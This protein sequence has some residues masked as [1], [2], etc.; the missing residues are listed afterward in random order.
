MSN[1]EF[2]WIG[3][4]ELQLAIKR[5]PQT[6]IDATR[7]FLTR[8]LAIYKKGIITKPWRMDGNGGGAPVSNTVNRSNTKQRSGNLRDTHQTDISGFVGR[9]Y[10][11]APYAAYVHGIEGMP[12]TR[13]YKLRP[14]LNHVK[15]ESQSKIEALYRQ[16]LANISKDLAR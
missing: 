14:W 9:I 11:T 10:P 5:N 16:L 13:S 6:V 3:M 4:G 8:G 2:K 1:A 12:R 7:T 15:T